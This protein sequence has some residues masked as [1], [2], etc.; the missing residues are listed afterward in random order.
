MMSS[1][2]R[3]LWRKGLGTDSEPSLVEEPGFGLCL[4]P[5][6]LDEVFDA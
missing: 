4:Q 2:L 6:S 3:M 1:A 5:K